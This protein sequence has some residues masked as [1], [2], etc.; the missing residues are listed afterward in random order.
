VI[1]L[2]VEKGRPVL[3]DDRKA[4]DIARKIGIQVI[5]SLGVLAKSKHAGYIDAAK[6]LLEGMQKQGIYFGRQLIEHFL[7][8]MHEM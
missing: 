2:A 6:P 1:T 7:R 8:D 4:R 5:G 3:L